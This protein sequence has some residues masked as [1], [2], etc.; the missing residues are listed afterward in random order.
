MCRRA[1]NIHAMQLLV[2]GHTKLER[3]LRYLGIEVEDV[4]ELSEQT[5]I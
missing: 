3:N 2:V 1:E 4:L 5:E